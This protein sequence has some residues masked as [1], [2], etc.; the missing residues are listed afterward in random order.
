M[1]EIPDPVSLK[2]RSLS[3]S[4]PNRASDLFLRIDFDLLWVSFDPSVKY[5]MT[6]RTRVEK[7]IVYK[8][9]L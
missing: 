8:P 4:D 6:S 2:S 7:L 1:S 3:G 9:L 5:F